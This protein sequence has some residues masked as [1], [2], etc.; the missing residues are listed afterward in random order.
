M[1]KPPLASSR[2]DTAMTENESNAPTIQRT[3]RASL[4]DATGLVRV[5][6]GGTDAPRCLAG[7]R[8]NV[9]PH[10]AGSPAAPCRKPVASGRRHR[11]QRFS[12]IHRAALSAAAH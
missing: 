1:L 9:T 12:E 11:P 2:T 5:W 7:W 3:T 6:V 8:A 4:L 10:R